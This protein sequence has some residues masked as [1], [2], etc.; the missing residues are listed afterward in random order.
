[1]TSKYIYFILLS[2]CSLSN[3]FIPP[4]Y[5]KNNQYSLITLKS[6]NKNITLPRNTS[7]IY[8]MDFNEESEIDLFFKPK[9]MFGLSDFH[10]TFLRIYVY[11][12]IYITILLH[13]ID[14]K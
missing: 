5:N 10:M 2:I 1:M 4:I 13:F 3:G 9:Y 6:N 12:Y 14:K 11:F 8:K 7:K